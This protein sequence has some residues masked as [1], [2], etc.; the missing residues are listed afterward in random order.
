MSTPHFLKLESYSLTIRFTLSRTSRTLIKEEKVYPS[1]EMQLAYST[2]PANLADKVTIVIYESDL[3]F[4]LQSQK[5][6]RHDHHLFS[7]EEFL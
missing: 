1:A 6:G 7:Q 3:R 2:A 4:C 5:K